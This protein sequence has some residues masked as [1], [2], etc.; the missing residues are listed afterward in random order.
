MAWPMVSSRA[1]NG[2]RSVV[3]LAISF[4]EDEVRMTYKL[5][6][7]AINCPFSTALS[8]SPNSWP[9]IA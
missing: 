8:F 6:K 5:L 1:L 4:F 3:Q 9:L 7:K 2:T